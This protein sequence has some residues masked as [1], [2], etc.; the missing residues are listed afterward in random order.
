[1]KKPN[2]EPLVSTGWLA[3]VTVAVSLALAES[4]TTAETAFFLVGTQA[5]EYHAA[6]AYVL[7]L[8]DPADI[9]GAREQ[10]SLDHNA[11][12]AVAVTLA[13][14]ND[15][16]N[17]NLLAPG[18]PMWSWHVKE[19]SGF[20]EGAIMGSVWPLS[21]VENRLLTIHWFGREEFKLVSG[22]VLAELQPEDLFWVSVRTI[23]E[24]VLLTWMDLGEDY[25]YRVERSSSLTTPDWTTVAVV[26]EG[27]AWL[28]PSPKEATP[29]YY[30]VVA[31][32]T[33]QAAAGD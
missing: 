1:M 9:S 13:P 28:D 17:R 18:K 20:A 21:Y 7:P 12:L 30:R 5:T 14:G 33:D 6:E 23:P 24:G 26:T 22:R 25:R 19:F 27:P 8:S 4:G 3:A 31:E 32:Q 10:L 29:R 11:R 16:L 2:L 15:R